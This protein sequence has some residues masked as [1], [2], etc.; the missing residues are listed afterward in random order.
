MKEI[1]KKPTR[2][3]SIKKQKISRADKAVD[4]IIEKSKG[5]ENIISTM[6]KNVL[7]MAGLSHKVD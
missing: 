3:H 7:L 5:G 1:R 6:S 2:S 4:K